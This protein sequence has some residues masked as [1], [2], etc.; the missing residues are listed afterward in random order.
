MGS[1]LLRSEI[2]KN[3]QDAYYATETYSCLAESIFFSVYSAMIYFSLISFDFN[4]DAVNISIA[5]SS[6]KIFLFPDNTSKIF[7]SISANYFLLLAPSII[8]LSFSL[9]KSG[10]S[11]LTKIPNN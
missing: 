6:V 11:F 5:V 1:I 8:N 10:L 4:L 2:T 3:K 7:Y 9:S